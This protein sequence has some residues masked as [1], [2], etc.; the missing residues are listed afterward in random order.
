VIVGAGNVNHQ[1]LVDLSE[2]HFK[3]IPRKAIRPINNINKPE[4]HTSHLYMRDDEMINSNVGVF[5]NSPS[6]KDNDFYSFLLL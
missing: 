5:Y 6:W 3:S 4:F 2:Q 1:M